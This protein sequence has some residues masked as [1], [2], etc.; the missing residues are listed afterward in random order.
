VFLDLGANRGAFSS[1]VAHRAHRLLSVEV[2][3][4]YHPLIRHNLA[5]NNCENFRLI[6]ALVGEAGKV[7]GN[8]PHTTIQALLDAHNIEHMDFVKMD[9]EGS[10]FS[11]FKHPQW[12]QRVGAL[13][14]EVHPAYGNP[15]DIVETLTAEGFSVTMSDENLTPESHASAAEF[16]YAW[17]TPCHKEAP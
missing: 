1:L 11:Q 9:I 2:N 8:F 3:E 6:A 4:V 12:L 7:Q 16:I 10:E 14:L 15:Q 13:T 17:R 5:G